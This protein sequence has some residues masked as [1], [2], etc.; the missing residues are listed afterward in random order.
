MSE[1]IQIPATSAAGKSVVVPDHFKIADVTQL[2]GV[3]LG[4]GFYAL[5]GIIAV[6]GVTRL[7]KDVNGE[8]IPGTG[9]QVKVRDWIAQ[10]DGVVLGDKNKAQLDPNNLT[11][12][13]IP[14][15]NKT[16][17][18]MLRPPRV[19][20]T[21]GQDRPDFSTGV[22]TAELSVLP[23][24]DRS[25]LVVAKVVVPPGATQITS[26]MII[27]D[28]KF[29]LKNIDDV[30]QLANVPKSAEAV[31]TL[32][33][34]VDV[35]KTNF[36]VDS[37]LSMSNNELQKGFVDVFADSSGIDGSL[38]SNY[39]VDSVLQKV[40]VSSGSIPGLHA[41]YKLDENIGSL[42]AKDSSGNGH[43][44]IVFGDSLLDSVDPLVGNFL[45]VT[46]DQ[47][48]GGPGGLVSGILVDNFGLVNPTSIS[49][50][51]WMKGY[52][53]QYGGFIGGL[54]A[55]KSGST[56][57]PPSDF[58]LY[59]DGVSTTY[60]FLSGSG[61]ETIA[62]MPTPLQWVH[63]VMVYDTVA[64]TAKL[65]YDG[66]EQVWGIVGSLGALQSLYNQLY[67]GSLG[68][69]YG[70]TGIIG[71]IDELSVFTRALTPTEV[72]NIYTNKVLTLGGITSATVISKAHTAAT[73][74]TKAVIIAEGTSNSLGWKSR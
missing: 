51:V 44:G 61:Y 66:V 4:D 33:L 62:V 38:S 2:H 43:D 72:Q 34:L 7:I 26:G 54:F 64:G 40:E 9:L 21:D 42:L 10:V 41:Y 27:N 23:A 74:P 53:S 47:R 48:A 11:N 31:S 73:D 35:A 58:G 20:G 39:K 56:P 1:K 19:V 14:S 17:Y 36:K 32:D 18:I 37:I 55:L 13:A 68:P 29:Y 50:S 63:V 16:W 25:G 45:A 70:D 60:G 69:G 46:P 59:F 30:W 52:V 71:D 28:V 12:V 67:I 6:G 3:Q 22:L 8:V 65:Y 15:A 5:S 24:G 57:W 49:I